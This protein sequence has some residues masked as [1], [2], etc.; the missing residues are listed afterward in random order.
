MYDPQLLAPMR[1]EMVDMG[2]QELTTA[3]EVESFSSDDVQRTIEGFNEK[4]R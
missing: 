1:Q 4:P 3:A 2:V